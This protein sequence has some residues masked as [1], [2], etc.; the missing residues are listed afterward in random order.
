MSDWLSVTLTEELKKKIYDDFTQTLGSPPSPPPIKK[1]YEEKYVKGLEDKIEKA[2]TILKSRHTIILREDWRYMRN[3][4][5]DIIIKT[6]NVL[7]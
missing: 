7:E 4:I 5:D 2:L 3:L 6:E 1:I